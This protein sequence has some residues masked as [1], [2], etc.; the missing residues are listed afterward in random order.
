MGQMEKC[1][2]TYDAKSMAYDPQVTELRA[3]TKDPKERVSAIETDF[4]QVP[5][6]EILKSVG[7]N[8]ATYR[9]SSPVGTAGRVAARVKVKIEVQTVNSQGLK[10][11]GHTII[12]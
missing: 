3:E 2:S 10:A 6:C 11:R 7:N 9:P 5:L 4:L 8:T 1:L 12:K